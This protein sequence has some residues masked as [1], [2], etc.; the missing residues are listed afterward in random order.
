MS[1]VPPPRLCR[2]FAVTGT[3]KSDTNGG[4]GG[5]E[6]DR[7]ALQSV[8]VQF[9]ANGTVYAHGHSAPSRHPTTCRHLDRSA[10]P[11]PDLRQPVGP[12]GLAA[13]RACHRRARQSPGDDL[14]RPAVDRRAAGHRVRNDARSCS[15]S[16]L[17]VLLFFDIFI[18]VAMNVQGSALS[19]RRHA[20]VMNRLHGLWSLGSVAGGV[21]TVVLAACRCQHPGPPH[22]RGPR[23]E[24]GPVVRRPRP[25]AP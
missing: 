16:R 4:N 7:R 19:A 15:S 21:T 18:D 25:P 14:R 2:S 10:R 6:V 22:G 17:M 24:R 5:S 20:P 12:R 1:A 11:R 8:A 3:Q 9:F 13:D 23:A